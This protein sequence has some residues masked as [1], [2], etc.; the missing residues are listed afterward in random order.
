MDYWP[1]Y[2]ILAVL[3]I[4]IWL[5]VAGRTKAKGEGKAKKNPRK[6]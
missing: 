6:R 4:D 3:A 5:I 2:L 1:F